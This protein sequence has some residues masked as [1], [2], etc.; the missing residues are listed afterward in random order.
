VV[1]FS[2]VVMHTFQVGRRVAFVAAPI[3]FVTGLS[4]DA[5]ACGCFA[6]PIPTPEVQ[7]FAVNQ[8][9]EQIV[10]EVSPGAVSAHVRIL[11]QGDP[12][13]F[14]WLLPV[15][16]VPDL[17]LS[18]TELFALL[19][20]RTSPSV[21][22]AS[23]SLCP[24]QRYRCES[25]PQC[26][27]PVNAAAGS[28]PLA[29][30]AGSP[31]ASGAMPNSPGAAPPVTVLASARVGAYDTVTFAASEAELAIEWLNDNG[32]IV[33]ETMSPYMQPYL[34]SGMVFVAS[35]LVPGSDL[36][37]IRPLK[38]T[39]EADVPAIPLRL[40]AIAA[41]PHMT[42]TALIFADEEYDPLVA[43]LVEFP[44][45][46]LQ[47]AARGNY[48]M[49]LARAVDDMG[50]FAFVKEYAG[51]G[52]KFLDT[53]GC[54]GAFMP[55]V[56]AEPS[57][58]SPD[59]GPATARDAGASDAGDV[60]SDVESVASVQTMTPLVPAPLASADICGVGNDGQ[61]Q[62]PGSSFDATDCGE[63][64]VAAFAV[65]EELSTKYRVLT[66]LSTRI[67][68]E[69]MI[70]DP[71]FDRSSAPRGQFRAN[72]AGQSQTLSNCA[73]QVIDA[74]RYAETVARQACSS[75]YCDFGEC[76]L[77]LEGA[78]C[79]CDDGFAARVF[80]D[81]DNLPSITCV[82][83]T[84]TVD[85]AAGGLELESAC[86]Y[87]PVGDEECL[88]LG[89]FPAVHCPSSQGAVIGELNDDGPTI[90]RC[91]PLVSRTS[92]PG[93][94]DFGDE[95][96]EFEVCNPPPP[97]CV[98]DGWLVEVT[99][100]IEGVECEPPDPSWFDVPP[101]PVCPPISSPVAAVTPATAGTTAGNDTREPRPVSGGVASSSPADQGGRIGGTLEMPD[102]ADGQGSSGCGVARGNGAA[103]AGWAWALLSLGAAARM[104]WRPL[105]R[106]RATGHS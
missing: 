106:S 59:A 29:D 13:Q 69:E 30:F 89:G 93:A 79:M 58:E 45:Q 70:E 9:A 50:G 43:P 63:D 15:P 27:A 48:P 57:G 18:H 86:D 46:E 6:P 94:Q 44:T 24:A 8:R 35:K 34:D 56:P 101:P 52:P 5:S 102:G 98:G 54:C 88:D 85:F 4:G 100:G 47:N 99:G 60:G 65:A 67:S 23:S 97:T 42:V 11:Y 105:K 72:F 41:E 78:G 84:A 95:F 33:N 1:V 81:V 40:T 31:V 80:T 82:R 14:A 12:E 3:A 32:F 75:I 71:V 49:V 22:Y 104:R 37:E 26:P 28:Q 92:S 39:Y 10:F 36:D 73:N 17:E 90:A 38:L 21:S 51:A 61:C 20:Q 16:S 74:E 96:A 2:E 77:T 91:S 53:T 25:H 68:P 55:Q 64:L 87:D 103:S 19:D 66:R 83:D 7:T 62:C 76:V